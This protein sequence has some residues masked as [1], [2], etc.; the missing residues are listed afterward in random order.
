MARLNSE[1]CGRKIKCYTALILLATRVLLAFPNFGQAKHDQ[2]GLAAT[3][4]P[5]FP[6]VYPSF[7][8]LYTATISLFLFDKNILP[9]NFVFD[10][11]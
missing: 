1:N 8:S 4:R 11:Y 5:M 10:Y 6:F 7:N 9:T 3:F 2:K